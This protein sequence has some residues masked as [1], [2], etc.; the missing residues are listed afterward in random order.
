MA[1]NEWNKLS[2]KNPGKPI[3]RMIDEQAKLLLDVMIKDSAFEFK[4][5]GGRVY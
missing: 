3:K 1:T 2:T 4:G 5:G